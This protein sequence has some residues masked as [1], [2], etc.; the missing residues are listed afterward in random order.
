MPGWPAV[1]RSPSQFASIANIAA[2]LPTVSPCLCPFI[3]PCRVYFW[4]RGTRMVR[5]RD[6]LVARAV[7]AASDSKVGMHGQVSI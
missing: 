3:L 2:Q 1:A 5:V 6:P 7:L 4:Q